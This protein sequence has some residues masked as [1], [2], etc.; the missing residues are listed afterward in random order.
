MQPC[1][2][3][4]DNIEHKQVATNIQADSIRYGTPSI[5]IASVIV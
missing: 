4:K 3:N 1:L 5:C 2:S